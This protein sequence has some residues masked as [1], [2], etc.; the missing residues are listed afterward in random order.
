MPLPYGL[1][2]HQLIEIVDNE[3]ILPGISKI[4][5]IGEDFPSLN[6]YNFNKIH[7]LDYKDNV[8]IH[9]RALLFSS[10]KENRLLKLIKKYKQKSF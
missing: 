6:S 8:N 3:R 7:S 9:Q 4:Y 10:G 5:Q 2:P 1:L